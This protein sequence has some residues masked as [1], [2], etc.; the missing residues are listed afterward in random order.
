MTQTSDTGQKVLQPDAVRAQLSRVLASPDFEVPERLR[1]FLRFVVEELLAG[2]GERIKAYTIATHVF[3]RGQDFDIL[4]DPVVRIEA[5]RLRRALERYYLLSGRIDPIC[6][7]IPKGA[8]IPNITVRHPITPPQELLGLHPKVA[9]SENPPRN[10]RNWLRKLGV[11]VAAV[12][13]IL[14]VIALSGLVTDPTNSS[15][16]ATS[17]TVALVV[18]P[19]ENLSGAE[20]SIYAAGISDELLNQ[21]VRFRELRLFGR[22]AGRQSRHEIPAEQPLEVQYLLEGG[23]RVAGQRLRVS[24]RLLDGRTK[25][26]VWSAVYDR[27]L[28]GTQNIDVES[29]IAAKVAAAVAQPYGAI[30]APIS[31]DASARIP[32]G[33]KPHLCVLQFYRYRNEPSREEHRLVRDCLKETVT[34]NPDYSTGWAMLA[35]LFLDED[36]LGFNSQEAAPAAKIRARE[37][38]QRAVRL[39]PNNVRALQALMAVLFFSREPDAALQIGEQA[40]VL[41]PNDT[42]ILAEFG[43]RLAQ[44]GD[45]RRGVAMIEEAVDRNP[46]QTKYYIAILAQNY[47]LIGDNTRALYWL[48]RANMQRFAN[49]HFVAALIFA[50]AHLQQETNASVHEFMRMRPRF[51]E[52]IEAEIATR[53]YNA[54]DRLTL[55]EGARQA[56]FPVSAAIN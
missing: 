28:G 52:N 40:L 53:N 36:R 22:D 48:R 30:F 9:N 31:G 23:V 29:D 37:A 19:F 24:S 18:S 13:S 10:P 11:P 5:S 20:G 17:P 35:Y 42:E 56:G 16:L 49:Y 43:S 50:R 41:N 3:G 34:R 38:A 55:I 25:E 8:Y 12:I 45:R 14:L 27:D 54:Q 15:Q 32:A 51:I 47:Y 44:A 6:I 26:I 39:D 21:L 1:D 7:D 33:A 2:R 46:N 4:N